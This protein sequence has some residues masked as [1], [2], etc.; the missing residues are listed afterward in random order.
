MKRQILFIY[1]TLFFASCGKEDSIETYN[2]D[3]TYVYFALENNQSSNSE[4]YADS[5]NINFSY[6][7]N[8]YLPEY[9]LKIPVNISGLPENKD[10]Q[11]AYTIDPKS[12]YNT[13]LISISTP[14]IQ[15]NLFVDTLRIIVKNDLELNNKTM[16]VILNLEKNDE[17]SVGNDYNS[18]IKINFTSQ[19]TRPSWWTTWEKYFGVYYK[20]VFQAWIQIYPEGID[21]TPGPLGQPYYYYWNNMPATASPT[22]FPVCFM[23]KDVLK[24]FFL[25]NAIYPNNDP[26]LTRIYLPQ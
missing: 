2:T 6:L 19:L 10:R 8:V 14:M 24:K 16:S 12:N 3:N 21:P 4:I 15:S 26:T 1:L 7:S 20:E 23:Y 13:N 22:S 5:V 25:D 18:S 11:F 17:F 9:E